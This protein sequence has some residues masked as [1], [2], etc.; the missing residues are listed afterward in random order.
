MEHKQY[1][2]LLLYLVGIY[3]EDSR[4]KSH[5]P[6]VLTLSELKDITPNASLHN[7]QSTTTAALNS[8]YQ[9]NKET[10]KLGLS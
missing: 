8:N 10:H 1:N 9:N 5:T 4:N 2:K 3:G 7:E 6:M